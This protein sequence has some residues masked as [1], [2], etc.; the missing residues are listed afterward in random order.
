MD[1]RPNP[2]EK[3]NTIAF[4]LVSGAVYIKDFISNKEIGSIQSS[5]IG[6]QITASK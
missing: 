6:E 1:I 3:E 4:L 2:G 5:K